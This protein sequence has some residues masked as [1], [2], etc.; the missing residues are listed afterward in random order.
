MR[1]SGLHLLLTHQCT[2]E[3]DH[4]FVWGSPWQSGTMKLRDVR[5]ILQQAQE[6]G[7]IEWIYFEG[8]EP[9]LYYPILVKG[10]EEAAR[11][12]FKVGLVTNGYW[13]TD[14]ESALEWLK[15][16][17]GWVQDLAVSSD[18]YHWDKTLSEK[19]R[20]ASAVAAQLGIPLGVISIARPEESEGCGAEGQ[21]PSGKSGIM[22]RGRAAQKLAGQAPQHPWARFGE[23]PYENLRDPGRVHI[24]PAGNLHVCQG[25][26][27]GSLFHVP[28]SEIVAQYD[29][30]SHPIVGPLLAGG[31]AEL[32]K[33]YEVPHSECYADACH[34]CY[35][36]RLALRDR[37]P[38]ILTPDQVYGIM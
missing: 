37:F 14:E 1:L 25:I 15:P 27:L 10:V 12:G 32:V 9:F 11:A 8:G 5:C 33:V 26:S 13:A 34:L 21:L 18:L 17:A 38:E 22:Y 3:C 2:L 7:S 23:C 28:L 24:D 35:E 6:L 4:C 19:A 36:A 30:D 29:P 20:I 16:M 31:P